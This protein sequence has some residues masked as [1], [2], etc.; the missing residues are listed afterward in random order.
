MQL[1]Q[2]RAALL[3]AAEKIAEEG[4]SLAGKAFIQEQHAT[5]E[6]QELLESARRQGEEVVRQAQDAAEKLEAEAQ[7]HGKVAAVSKP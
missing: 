5:G 6:H 2:A 4:K 3:A 7:F 1:K